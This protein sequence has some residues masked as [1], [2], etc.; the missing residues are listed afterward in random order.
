MEAIVS[1]IL[2]IS[3]IL[4]AIPVAVFFIE[5]II[6]VA[7]PKRPKFAIAR[8]DIGRRVAVLV[9]AHNES[10]G[11]LPTLADIKSQLRS[12]DRVIV[13]ADNCTD[14]TAAVAAAAGAEVIERRDP[15]RIGKGYA[16]DCGIRHL[17][18]DPPDIVILIDADCRLEANAIV[19]LTANCVMTGRPVQA[20][21][22]MTAPDQSGINH[23]VAEFAWRVKNWIRPLGLNALGLPC[24]L[25]GTGMALPW[26]VMR[27]A[28][29]ATA[30]I[31]EDL[32]LGL[33]LAKAGHPPI[34]CPSAR[35]TSEFASST[36][37]AEIQRSRWEHG[38]IHTIVSV[39][40]KLIWVALRQNNK[41]LL[42]LTLD[43]VVPPLS[44]LVMLVVGMFLLASFT[45]LIGLSAAP[46]L[47]SMGS[48]LALLLATIVAW[49]KC[50]RI[51]L[52]LGATL[53]MAPYALGKIGL[54]GRILFRRMETRWI[55]TDRSKSQ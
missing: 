30:M 38:H 19:Q 54:Y 3:A 33:D 52:P 29:L 48:F 15:D 23:R 26:E 41:G 35:V 51:V 14:D 34:F 22:L 42:A 39:A 31:V 46:M 8:D 17:S 16:L 47:I 7:L 43:L 11:L 20:L 5:I 55:R 32:Q 24:Q 25:M 21:Y 40:P 37:G 10:T 4:L 1:G 18:L 36:K 28:D 44:L 27:S 6:A 9:P 53:S 2:V 12:G 49:W 13:V 50:G 45:A